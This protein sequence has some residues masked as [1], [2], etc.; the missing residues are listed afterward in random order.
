MTFLQPQA[1][2]A[3]HLQLPPKQQRLWSYHCQA[4]AAELQKNDLVAIEAAQAHLQL[5]LVEAARLAQADSNH[6]PIPSQS[7]LNEVFRTINTNY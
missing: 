2:T 5:L 6:A 4:L 3:R 7:V 1:R